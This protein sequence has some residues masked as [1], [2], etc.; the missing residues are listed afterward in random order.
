MKRVKL[1]EEFLLEKK[2][3]WDNVW[4]KRKRGE[5]PAKPGDEDYPDEDAWKSAQEALVNENE[6]TYSDYPAT[7]KKNAKKALDWREEYGRDEVDAGTA[8]GW[9]RANQLA[10]GESLSRDVVSRMAQFNRHRKN[11][12]IDPKFKDTPWKDRGYVAWL[13]WGGTEGVDWAMKKMDQIKKEEAKTNE[14]VGTIFSDGMDQTLRTG[15]KVELMTG[16]T[17]V[18]IDLI[19]TDEAIVLLGNGVTARVNPQSE[20]KQIIDTT[21]PTKANGRFMS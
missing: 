12:A 1:F 10:K 9:Q 5:K 18:I 19:G 15:Y 6:E 11:S 17:G 13:I 4:A 2:G 16:D 20:I 3:L 14:D 21:E 7:A 8:V